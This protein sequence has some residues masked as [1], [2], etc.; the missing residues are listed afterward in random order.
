MKQFNDNL[1]FK[2]SSRSG[3]PA[4]SRNSKV[5]KVSSHCSSSSSKS[6]IKQ[7][8]KTAGLEAE[9]ETLRRNM[10]TIAA[11]EAQKKKEEIKSKLANIDIQIARS[12]AVE[13]IFSL[14]NNAEPV[15]SQQR[16]PSN[17]PTHVRF[18]DGKSQNITPQAVHKA[19][20]KRHDHVLAVPT[21]RP[22]SNTTLSRDIVQLLKAPPIDLDVFSGDLLEYDYFK[23]NFVE[24]VE[25]TVDDQRGR[26][27]RLIKYTS[28]EPKELIKLCVYEDPAHC[29][30]NAMARLD[31]KYG[32]VHLISSSFLKQLREWPILKINDTA[33][34]E[35]LYIFLQKCHIYKK[36]GGLG[37]LDND[38]FM[39]Q[40]VSKLDVTYHEAWR[41]KAENLRRKKARE[42]I[43]DDL[44]EF[45]DFQTSSASNPAY[46]R[47]M[48]K[49]A[50]E[51][52]FQV[53][54]KAVT[55]E[56]TCYFCSIDGF[57]KHTTASCPVFVSK[58]I[59]ERYKMVFEHKL[60]FG[61]LEPISVDHRGKSCKVRM[62]CS[63]CG[64]L[65]PTALHKTS[66]DN[67]C[68]LDSNIPQVHAVTQ[69]AMAIQSKQTPDSDI[70]MCIVPVLV[71][72]KD[73]PAN[74]KLVY[75]LLDSDCT[76][77][78]CVQ[79]LL[80]SLASKQMRK[81]HVSVETLNGRTEEVSLAANG[82][83]VKCVQKHAAQYSSI[84]VP[85]PT[86]YSCPSLP[87]SIDD[88][89]TADRLQQWNYLD[90]VS[91]SMTD[92]NEG[93]S[94][95]LMI[96]GNCMKAL[97]PLQTILSKDNGPY[98]FRTRLGWCVVGPIRSSN[99]VNDVSIKCNFTNVS[100][101]PKFNVSDAATCAMANHHFSTKCQVRDNVITDTLLDMYN[102]DFSE[103]NTEERGL[104]REDGRFLKILEDGVRLSGGHF[105]VP[106]PF[107]DDN[108]KLPNNRRQA[109]YRLE[110]VKRRMQRDPKYRLDYTNFVNGIIEKRA[111]PGFVLVV[112]SK[113]EHG[114]FLTTEFINL[115]SQKIVV[116]LIAVLV[117]KVQV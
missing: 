112:L 98:A 2:A 93:I 10:D 4:S 16:I 22:Y 55:S 57:E 92:A 13:H 96:G 45:I 100:T 11:A 20:D 58:N 84:V 50:K 17:N 110:G 115:Q 94:F 82:L 31:K 71:S 89:P 3:K 37:I 15:S 48:I 117:T 103:T 69:T 59:D 6:A 25:R 49:E 116:C 46:S 36:K 32:N 70:S 34:M 67:T 76:G 78:F 111:M 12:K 39:R 47:E 61:C 99:K 75:A 95:G 62:K 79:D 64:K 43:F 14:G 5:S 52:V 80:E 108:P 87:L 88:V 44:L 21:E 90:E 74:E 29:Y 24:V 1:S 81:A 77:C 27:A 19:S 28:G 18:L 42:P 35:K 106:L 65:H 40:V 107:R 8:A 56:D 9:A 109:L 91:R 41:R 7:R 85:L 83:V 102:I 105:E 53:R 63:S 60:C 30:D 114:I 23:S 97:E 66:H 73:D 38:I 86:T 33:G 104:S 68:G 113:I 54:F 26:L 101:A 72:H 51:K